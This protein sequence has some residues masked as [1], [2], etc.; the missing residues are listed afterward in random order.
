MPILTQALE[1]TTAIRRRLSRSSQ[2]EQLSGQSRW[3]ATESRPLV[4]EHTGRADLAGP[5]LAVVPGEAKGPSGG[6]R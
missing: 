5:A 6:A 2:K 3:Q 4:P 1:D